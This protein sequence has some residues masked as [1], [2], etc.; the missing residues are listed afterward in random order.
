[1]SIYLKNQKLGHFAKAFNPKGKKQNKLKKCC[2]TNN[3]NSTFC[4]Q[5]SVQ[6]LKN[7]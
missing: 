5:K 2:V 6:R 3:K 1:M 7:S 4:L